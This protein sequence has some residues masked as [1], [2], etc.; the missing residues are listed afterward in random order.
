MSVGLDG[1]RV[2]AQPVQRHLAGAVQHHR[3]LHLF[4]S[5]VAH[6]TRHDHSTQV[7]VDRHHELAWIGF[8]QVRATQAHRADLLTTSRRTT[9]QGGVL[10]QHGRM[11]QGITDSVVQHHRDHFAVVQLAVGVTCFRCP[12]GPVVDVI[13]T[14][15]L[16]ADVLVLVLARRRIRSRDQ[17]AV[18]GQV[19]AEEDLVVVRIRTIQVETTVDLHRVRHLTGI[20]VHAPGLALRTSANA[21]QLVDDHVVLGHHWQLPRNERALAGGDVDGGH[22]IPT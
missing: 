12:D 17:D 20:N 18:V 7:D 21:E 9:H 14:H 22:Q 5:V 13:V 16:K 19:R 4:A 10:H 6:H 11:A 2:P 15:V 1:R 8:R 3:D